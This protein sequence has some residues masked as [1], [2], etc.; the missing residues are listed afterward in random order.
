MKRQITYATALL[1]LIALVLFNA[2]VRLEYRV[3]LYDYFILSADYTDAERAVLQRMSPLVYG[4]NISEPPLGM[5]N[6]DNGQYTGMVVD[7]ISALSIELG[8]T[9]ISQPMVWNDA[10]EA[11]KSGETDLCD[12][13]LSPE[14]QTQFAFTAPIYDLSGVIVVPEA[15]PITGIGNLNGRRVVVQKGDYAIE[16]LTR[17][18]IRASLVEV[19]N[20]EQAMTFLHEGKADALIGDEPVAFYT[21]GVL[22]I[23]GEYRV[24]D[25]PVYR[26]Q[27]SLGVSRTNQ[28]LLG[29]LDKA[30]FRLR[31][32][33]ILAQI[34][35][36]WSSP[37]PG[38]YPDKTADR[39][40]LTLIGVALLF[41][42]TLYLI[43]FWSRSL[44]VLV[45]IRT[46][47]LA[48][49]KDELQG[50]FDSLS[51]C[52]AVI[53][54]KGG[55]VH[56]NR[57]LLKECTLDQEAASA[58]AYQDIP[59]LAAFNAAADQ[60]L[61]KWT[62]AVNLQGCSHEGVEFR[63]GP[64]IFEGLCYPLIQ[65]DDGNRQL[66]I[67]LTDITVSRMKDM[68]LLH[69]NKM[70]AVGMLAAGVAHE[71]R[72]PLGTIRNSGFVLKTL[73][74]DDTEYRDKAL[75]AIENAVE[76]AGGIIDN[77]LK[78]SRLTEDRK[79][80]VMLH[81]YLTEILTLFRQ[82]LEAQGVAAVLDCASSVCVVTNSTAL[83]HGLLNIIQNALDV[84]PEGGTLR[85]STA[86][87]AD[88]C[89]I[90][91]QDSGPG[92]PPQAM[93]RIFDPFYTTKPVGQGTG[94]GLYVAYSEIK[95]AGGILQAD[96]TVDNGACFALM[97]PAGG[98]HAE[99]NIEAADCG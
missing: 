16:Y 18:G 22:G 72:N 1:F 97:L 99:G 29:V 86:F 4:G 77:M 38:F 27:V 48:L 44:K 33:G 82:Q 5:L 25:P 12:M 39:I 21:L 17:N 55:V 88:Q 24:L 23:A 42:F 83:W 89:I 37:A 90:K 20:M 3:G 75:G 94:L 50:V 57:T 60:C 52:L 68:R 73:D 93:E 76:R 59:L 13:M 15:S 53:G 78:H 34:Q 80:R 14:R 36:K 70:E 85:I 35:K 10:L 74:P 49:M 54:G 79:D 87:T 64:K 9:I 30:V 81:P 56:F 63:V 45:S 28:A 26:N 47:E 31:Q 51:S 69:A 7:F 98:M 41:S 46:R 43:W 6:P 8:E 67:M 95:R 32:K 2:Y 61:T 40:K 96:S 19:D 71:L 91:I 66:L 84:M 11:L 58:M 92:I 65:D 62:E